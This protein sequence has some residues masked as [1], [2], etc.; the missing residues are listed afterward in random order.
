VVEAS[1]NTM[2][3]AAQPLRGALPGET[4]GLDTVAP[5]YEILSVRARDLANPLRIEGLEAVFSG[6]A[7]YDLG[8]VRW[9]SGT[10]DRFTGDITT[11]YLRGSFYK[12]RITLRVG[13]EM[14]LAGNGRMLQL[15]GGDL[16]LRLPAG[17]SLSA[18]AGLPVSQRFGTRAGYRT[19]NPAGG[20]RAYGG[21]LGWSWPWSG[22][23][24]RSLD[25]GVSAVVVTD[26]GYTARK[27]ASADARVQPWQNVV[28]A[29]NATYSLAAERLAELRGDLLWTV[30]P[31]LFVNL[32]AKRVAPDLFLSQNSILSVFA[33]ANRTDLGAGLRYQV[34]HSTSVGLDYAALIEPTG[35]G[36]KTE[37]G[38]QAAGRVEWEHGKSKVGGEVSYLQALG[39]GSKENGY[40]GA[41]LFGRH[42][43]RRLFLSAD[44]TA[45]FLK[46]EVNGNKTSI[47]GTLAAGTPL[48]HGWEAVLAGHAGVTPLLSQQFDLMAK[49]V[50][51]Q[52]YRTSE[53][54]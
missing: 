2:V 48:G 13:R 10:P 3:V 17:V 20:D 25:L 42:D 9:S 44:A 50:Y 29:A 16:L 34:S 49:L 32:G 8:D 54:K 7:S 1:S 24:G 15:D 30:N 14:V 45:Y 31:K 37:L 6:W 35:E 26:N 40:T 39:L 11:G 43:Y 22:F 51:N 18:F 4:P 52:T 53:V 27:D 19:W 46:E 36:S 47:S 38:H 23:P 33:D 21:R 28:L 12:R 5:I 41:R